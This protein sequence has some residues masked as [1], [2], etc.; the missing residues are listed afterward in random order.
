MRARTLISVTSLFFAACS[1]LNDVANPDDV[2]VL[3]ASPPSIPAN[4]Y[5]VTLVSAQISTRSD[6]RLR[7]VIFT[8]TLGRFPGADP[9]TPQLIVA[10]AG[11]DGRASVALQSTAQTGTAVVSAEIRESGAVKISQSIEVA[12]EAMS[13]SEVVVVIPSSLTAPADGATV[14][15][16]EAHIAA[17]I[18]VQQRSVVFTTTAGSFATLNPLTTTRNADAEGIAIAN[19]MSPRTPTVA[20]VTATVNNIQAAA[21]V[22]FEQALPDR[23]AVSV[24][25]NL[26]LKATFATKVTVE[27]QLERVV[28]AVTEGTEVIFRAFDESTGS[29]F[30]FF[31]GATLSDATGRVTAEFTPGNTSERGE[32]TIRVR[33]PGTDILGRVRI[34]IVDP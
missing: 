33:V 5:S 13:P 25:G 10:T 2:L 26:Q 14:T 3:T 23:I 18:P 12:F 30:G 17:G 15:Q 20:V 6:E 28:G 27:A 7:D 21:S 24:F 11:S 1:G 32:A 9:A 31:S 34:E 22:T 19:L 4:G 29:Q 8:T 16:I